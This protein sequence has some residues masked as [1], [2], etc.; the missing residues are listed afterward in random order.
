MGT[1]HFRAHSVVAMVYATS[2]THAVLMGPVVRRLAESVV[3]LE[4]VPRGRGVAIMSSV[5]RARIVVDSAV[6]VER[7][8]ATSGHI[9]LVRI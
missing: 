5:W 7:T 6:T 8:S 4:F 9:L 1:V 2:G 3:E